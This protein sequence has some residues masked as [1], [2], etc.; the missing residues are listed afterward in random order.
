VAVGGNELVCEEGKDKNLRYP[1]NP[2]ALHIRLGM[3]GVRV[4]FILILEIRGGGGFISDS[5]SQVM[6]VH[7]FDG[8]GLSQKKSRARR[9][10]Q[11]KI[12]SHFPSSQPYAALNRKQTNKHLVLHSSVIITFTFCPPI[13]VTSRPAS[14]NPATPPP[15]SLPRLLLSLSAQFSLQRFPQ[16]IHYT[17]SSSALI[18]PPPLPSIHSPYRIPSSAHPHF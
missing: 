17:S 16:V 18:L 13:V 4:V 7:K 14:S 10:Y 1:Q 11:I 3:D 6:V 2:M 9:E 12:K 8:W 5:G 15:L